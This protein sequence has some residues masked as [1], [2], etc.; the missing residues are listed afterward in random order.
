[1]GNIRV[2]TGCIGAR[3]HIRGILGL[4][5]LFLCVATSCL[6][7]VSFNPVAAE[8]YFSIATAYFELGKYAEAER[9]FTKAKGAD[10]TRNASEYNLGRI[11]FET[12][13]PEDAAIIF[14]KLRSKDPDNLLLLRSAAYSW[15]KAGKPEKALEHYTRIEKLLPLG[16]DSSF[17][18]S[19]LL[20]SLER[21]GEAA[22]KLRPYLENSP[23]DLDARVLLARCQVALGQPEALDSYSIYLSKKEDVVARY[24]YAGL[25]ES[26]EFYARAVENYD[27][28]IKALDGKPATDAKSGTPT[29]PVLRFAK[30]RSLFFSGSETELALAELGKALEAGYNDQD[31][32]DALSSDAR[33]EDSEQISALI[34]KNRAKKS[35]P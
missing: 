29:V 30:A 2:R 21:Y 15:A 31:A 7:C 33:I 32:L 26:A 17:N 3:R 4:I 11:A 34:E 22:E 35:T 13:R 25:C 8:E 28:L 19:L 27:I 23:D 12:G 10:K 16:K 5:T 6:S 24:E 9:W 18:H 14:E 1:M 20:Y